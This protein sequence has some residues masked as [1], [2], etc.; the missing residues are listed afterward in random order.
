MVWA[1][2]FWLPCL[3]GENIGCVGGHVQNQSILFA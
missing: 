1:V 2:S 3:S